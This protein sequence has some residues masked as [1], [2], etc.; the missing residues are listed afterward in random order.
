MFAMF[1]AIICVVEESRDGP[2]HVAGLDLTP[3]PTVR[4]LVVIS[5]LTM[6]SVPVMRRENDRCSIVFTY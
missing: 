2:L 4:D 6:H 1:G 5:P 3:S